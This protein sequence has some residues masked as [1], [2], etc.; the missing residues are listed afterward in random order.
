M[1]MSS[2]LDGRA[3]ATTMVDP[4]AWEAVFSRAV[5]ENRESVVTIEI[6]DELGDQE[7]V[8]GK[9]LSAMVPQTKQGKT[10]IE[11]TYEHYSW[12]KPE[13]LTHFVNDPRRVYMLE[14]PEGKIAGFDIE[15]RAG[16][17]VLVTFSKE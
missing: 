13:R 15:T 2:T 1:A 4:D 11:L 16:Q 8:K 17:K 14:R 10:E 9:W 12:D 6:L 7:L 3:A 5:E